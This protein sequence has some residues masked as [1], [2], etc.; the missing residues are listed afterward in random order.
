MPSYESQS[1]G[2]ALLEDQR[3]ALAGVSSDADTIRTPLDG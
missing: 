1:A 2:P 3:Q